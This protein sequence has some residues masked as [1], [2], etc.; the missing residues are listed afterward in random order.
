MSIPVVVIMAK[1]PQPGRSKTRLCPPYT[2]KQAASIAEALL[3]DTI[4][5]VN[6]IPGI[7]PAVAITPPEELSYFQNICPGHFWLLPVNGENIGECLNST[8]DTVLDKGHPKSIAINADG[9]DLPISYLAKSLSDLDTH[10]MVIGPTND[11]GYYLIGLKH[12]APQIFEG[13]TWSTNLVLNQTLERAKNSGLSYT[14]LPPWH[15]VDTGQE[16]ERLKLHL[17]NLPD[18]SLIHTR[19]L[20]LHLNTSPLTGK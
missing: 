11:G 17:K 13:I 4:D 12:T 1:K 14:I 7:Q 20:L 2:L 9:P 15:D 19:N 8:I 3:K 16:V 18:D 10:D 5:L 6:A